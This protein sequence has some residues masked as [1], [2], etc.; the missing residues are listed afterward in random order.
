MKYDMPGVPEMVKV[1]HIVLPV[2]DLVK[3]RNW[4]VENLGFKLERELDIAIGLKDASGLTIFLQKASAP[5][6]GPKIRLTIQVDNVDKKY[7]EL[8]AAGVKFVSAPK[9]QFWGYGAE[10]MDPDGYMNDLWD[11]V[12]MTRDSEARKRGE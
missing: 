5:S 11:E 9:R 8:A 1:T 12:T 7:E 6:T 4:Y 3:S 2:A 10:V